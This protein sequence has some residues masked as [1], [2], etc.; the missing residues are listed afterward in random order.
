MSGCDVIVIGAGHNGL[1]AANY[2]ADKGLRVNVLEANPEIGGMSASGYPFPK[3]PNHLVNYCSMDLVFWQVS[4]VARELNLAAYGLK[5]KRSD[6]AYAYLHPDGESICFWADANRTAEEIKYFSPQDAKN[7]LEYAEFLDRLMK[8]SLPAM[9]ANLARPDLASIGKLGMAAL[10]TMPYW[11]KFADFYVAS[12]DDFLDRKFSHPIVRNFINGIPHVQYPSDRPGTAISHLFIAFIHSTGCYRAVGGQQAIPNA[13]A[14]RLKSLGGVIETNAR[15]AQIIVDN[16]K[17]RG[18][19]LRDGRTI[20]AAKGMIATCDPIT[21]FTKLLPGDALSTD[22][23]A[24]AK[25]IQS[26]AHGTAVLKID[27]AL[28]GR[29]TL[30]RSQARRRD[31]LDLRRPL[32]FFGPVTE[33]RKAYATAGA[34]LIPAA[35][36][37][38]VF[39]CIPNAEE[40][41]QTPAGQDCLYAYASHFPLHPVDGW[42]AA[43]PAA[44][45]ALV[46]QVSNYYDGIE[47]LEIDRYISTPD[48]FTT[49]KGVA[50]GHTL[51]VDLPAFGPMRPAL[52]LGN[53]RLPVKNLFLGGAG[54]HPSGGVSGLP[55]RLAAREF[56]RTM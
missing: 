16:G 14:A 30:E 46:K 45:D 20:T 47:K 6:P 42:A 25:N 26:N 36:D 22:M 9:L 49:R 21:L 43:A 29:L 3:A 32:T 23:K 10:K 7:Y 13:M 52:G 5:T 28:S 35:E 50:N 41:S 39:C 15:V 31:D 51:H 33:G 56:L 18:V 8:V 48:D 2:L 17:A 53:H 11:R 54:A 19:V 4:P 44:V 12:A 55:G 1:T 37:I 34:G 24:R 27:I 40:E 38:T